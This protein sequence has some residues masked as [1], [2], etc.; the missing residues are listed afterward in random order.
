MKAIKISDQLHAELTSVVG[1]LIAESGKIK[2]YENA[3]EALL[4]RSIVLP[5][6]FVVEVEDFLETNKQ[7]GYINKEEFVREAA[8]WFMDNLNR[9]H[10]GGS[11]FKQ[12]RD[13]CAQTSRPLNSASQNLIEPNRA[14]SKEP[15]FKP[16]QMEVDKHG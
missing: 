7:F 14:P 1:Q 9:E 16:L 13:D 12:L 3:I 6:K 10:K 4:H 8:R 11:M 5:P 15:L 2:T